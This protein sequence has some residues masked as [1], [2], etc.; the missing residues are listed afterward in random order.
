MSELRKRQRQDIVHLAEC[1][2]RPRLTTRRAQCA[3]HRVDSPSENFR[4]EEFQPLGNGICPLAARWHGLPGWSDDLSD[5]GM[6][7]SLQQG[8][9]AHQPSCSENQHFHGSLLPFG[10]HSSWLS[11]FESVPVAAIAHADQRIEANILL[12]RDALG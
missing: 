9:L 12:T 11:F 5:R 6:C 1:F 10:S 8:A 4:Q 7:D 2:F 3:D